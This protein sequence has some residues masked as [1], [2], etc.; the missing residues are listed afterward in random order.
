MMNPLTL[1]ETNCRDLSMVR[2]RLRRKFEA[3]QSA[4][5][6]LDAVH[7]PAIRE[8][9][10]QCSML[11]VTLL[12]N[13]AAGRDLFLQRKTLEFHGI[14]VGFEKERDSL[15]LPPEELLVDRIRKMLPAAQGR[16][17]LDHTV[18]VIKSAFKK[19]PPDILQKLGCSI[20]KGGDRSIVRANDDD[21][22]ALVQKSLGAGATGAKAAD[23]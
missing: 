6:A 14:V 9:Q 21:I 12:D 23:N 22:E 20:I 4:Q 18:K 13:V 11:R 8:L 15:A 10:E 16:T 19:L 17:L 7:N 3:R 5:S 1:I 2:E